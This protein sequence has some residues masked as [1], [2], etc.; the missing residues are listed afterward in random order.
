M[1]NERERK[2]LRWLSGKGAAPFKGDPD[3]V[4]PTT[5]LMP[6][7]YQGLMELRHP[8]TN[9]VL[10]VAEASRRNLRPHE[11]CWVITDAGKRLMETH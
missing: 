9:E 6:L 11:V 1:G 5:Y 2:V 3:A 8:Q 7:I 4:D 10:T